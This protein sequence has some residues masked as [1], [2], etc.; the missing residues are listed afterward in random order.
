LSARVLFGIWLGTMAAVGFAMAPLKW[1][2]R[3]I[4]AAISLAVVLPP[5]T[6][7]GAIWINAAGVTAAA[8]VLAIDWMRQ[9]A[10]RRSG[11]PEAPATPY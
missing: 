10:L 6:F 3:M 7:T 9:R 11:A 1:T 5:E 8:A 4:Y 2:G